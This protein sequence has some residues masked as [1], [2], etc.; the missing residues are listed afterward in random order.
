MSSSTTRIISRWVHI[1]MAIPIIGYI[2][3]PFEE[4]PNYAP[5]VRFIAIP[6]IVLTGAWMWK[7]HAVWRLFAK[8]QAQQ[9]TAGNN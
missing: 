3:S 8:G 4:L 1:V 5:V 2:Y 7:G 6:V 9:S